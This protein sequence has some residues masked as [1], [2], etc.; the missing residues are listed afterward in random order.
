MTVGFV[1]RVRSLKEPNAPL[2]VHSLEYL[3]HNSLDLLR[4]MKQDGGL[5]AGIKL[6]DEQTVAAI[7]CEFSYQDLT[8]AVGF[9]QEPLEE[10]GSSLESAVTGMDERTMELLKQLRHA[11]PESVNKIV[12]QR[13]K[14]V[15]GMHKIG[16]D[17]SV[18]DEKLEPM[19]ESY[20]HILKAS[21]LEYYVFGHVAEN[22]LHVNILPRN[23]EELTQAERLAEEL[24]R[25]AVAFGGTVSAEHGIGKMK[26]HLLGLMFSES[27]INEMLATKRALDPN[28]ILSPGNIFEN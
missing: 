3:D 26:K 17:A 27:A 28:M 24:A 1:L 2:R 22:H 11:I 4:K 18:P 8:E 19:I 16:T 9:L 6:P 25:E 15:Q 13:K 14:Q 20:S 23:Q 10:F 21:S 12:A 7:L 5:G